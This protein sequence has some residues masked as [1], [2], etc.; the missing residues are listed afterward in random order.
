M[1]EACP[2]AWGFFCRGGAAVKRSVSCKQETI[3][4][5]AKRLE[6]FSTGIPPKS[7]S[8]GTDFRFCI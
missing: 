2:P 1:P 3:S 7:F 6:D 5:G 4:F 8:T